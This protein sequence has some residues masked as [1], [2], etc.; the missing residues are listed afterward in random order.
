MI[1]NPSRRT[2][3]QSS[4]LI[5]IL[6]P[7]DAYARLKAKFKEHPKNLHYLLAAVSDR[8]GDF[9]RPFMLAYIDRHGP[10][11]I[12]LQV[13]PRGYTMLGRR[14][15]NPG[16]IVQW[17]KR[18]FKDMR[19]ICKQY[20]E[21]E[22]QKRKRKQAEKRKLAKLQADRERKRKDLEE[23]ALD[24]Q[25]VG[26]IVISNLSNFF[27]RIGIDDRE[28]RLR[29]AITAIITKRDI[30]A[31]VTRVFIKADDQDQPSQATVIPRE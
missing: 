17:F 5:H 9:C 15:T 13:T 10:R 12:I 30:G 8:G 24:T 22:K 31:H 27:S 2:T 7:T 19:K 18:H 16:Q 20:E 1:K 3:D 4:S 26:K 6:Y 28:T 21:Q 11:R 29:E 25:S 14:M 23:K